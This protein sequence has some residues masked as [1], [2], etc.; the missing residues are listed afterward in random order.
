MKRTTIGIL[1]YLATEHQQLAIH[2][3]RIF[4][5]R[6]SYSA[7][8]FITGNLGKNESIIRMKKTACDF[9][10]SEYNII[11]ASFKQ[12]DLQTE[13]TTPNSS[14]YAPRFS[15]RLPFPIFAR[16]VICDNI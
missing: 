9:H 7:L 1:V 6:L 13:I 12:S 16:N 3:S 2:P 14:G 15:S 11:Q 4:E 8:T 10:F 5:S